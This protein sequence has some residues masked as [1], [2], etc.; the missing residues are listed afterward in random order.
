MI[1]K[2]LSTKTLIA[3]TICSC[4]LI[5]N[6]PTASTPKSTFV[7][8]ID[9]FSL[10]KESKEGQSLMAEFEK[11]R[12][13]A[14]K[15]LEDSAKDLQAQEETLKKQ[16][17]LLAQDVLR[18]KQQELER[19]ARDLTQDRDRAATTLN[20]KYQWKQEKLVTT[21]LEAAKKVFET[22]SSNGDGVLVDV[23]AP[24]VISVGKNTDITPEVLKIVNSDWDANQKKATK[25]SQSA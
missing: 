4:S 7:F 11:E 22:K 6:I 13:S 23:R 2:K 15:K 24:G 17:P 1:I 16:A 9:S 21:H 18:E 5:A 12:D 8:S 3:A 19:K 10:M 25:V 14:I 20:E